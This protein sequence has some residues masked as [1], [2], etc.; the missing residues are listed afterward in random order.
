MKQLYLK[1]LFFG[2]FSFLGFKVEAYDIIVDGIY[3][4]LYS[5]DKTASVTYFKKTSWST[6]EGAVTIPSIIKDYYG[7][8]Y[9]VTSI[10][11]EAFRGCYGLTS[12]AIPFSV[13][14]IGSSAFSGCRGLTSVTIPNSVTN[15]GGSAFQ[16]CYGLTSITIPNSV[17]SIGSYAFKG[18]SGLTSVTIPNSVT[19]FGIDVFYGTSWYNNRPDGLVYTGKVAYKYKGTMPENTKI[20]LLEGTKG[21]AGGA[22]S[23]CRGLT[24]ITIPFSV[25]N[26][27]AS[28]FSGCSGLTSITIPFSVTSIGYSAFSGCSGL[29]S[30]D[31]PS[32]VTIIGSSAFSGCT[33]LTSITI[34][35]S[36]NDI[37]ASAFSGCS[38]LTSLIINSNS[39]LS[40]DYA[41]DNNNLTGIFGNQVE[42]LVIGE[43]VTKIGSW[44]FLNSRSLTSVTLPNSLKIINDPT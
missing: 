26:I 29:N 36:I 7:A 38:S 41:S 44:A 15:I 2:I 12:I 30:I 10:G 4:N 17:T 1:C 39:V 13:T 24:S 34:P 40:K 23:S 8:T 11:E 43:G 28:A 9:R 19:S 18:C 16:D 32:S 5:T 25:T 6:Y 21:I 3:Y 35:N 42:E 27:G 14:S 22:F 37:G 31:I 20:T 33:G